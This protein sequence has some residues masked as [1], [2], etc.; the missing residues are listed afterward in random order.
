M[1]L[2]H[3]I[4]EVKEGATIDPD[5]E[6]LIGEVF[7]TSVKDD[8][9]IGFSRLSY[10]ETFKTVIV[11]ILKKSM[12]ESANPIL[13]HVYRNILDIEQLLTKYFFGFY[14]G[15]DSYIRDYMYISWMLWAYLVSE[16]RR[17]A[18]GSEEQAVATPTVYSQLQGHDL[19]LVTFNYTSFARRT[20]A[21]ALYFHGSLMEYVDVENKNDIAHEDLQGIGLADF[22]EN[23]LAK[24]ISFG[25]DRRSLPIPSFLPPLK[26]QTVISKR[27]IDAWYQT[28]E[29]LRHAKKVILLGINLGTIDPYFGDMLR[30]SDAPDIIVVDQDLEATATH[31]CGIFNQ[32]PKSYSRL[33]IAGHE[34]RKYNNRLTVVQA[35]LS[36][37]NLT[38]FL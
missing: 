34:A 5:T 27:Y 2:F 30:E 19:Q 14:D 36:D 8:T 18:T 23:R 7:G 15:R 20:K 33:Q 4:I 22:F 35:D 10:T 9:I 12:H 24:D 16:E 1:R 6:R 17:I 25:G 28:G 29:M 26:I 37:I 31:L 38:E 3:K 32:V 13:R 11:E 21:D